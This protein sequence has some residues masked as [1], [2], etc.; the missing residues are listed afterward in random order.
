VITGSGLYSFGILNLCADEHGYKTNLKGYLKKCRNSTQRNEYGNF[1]VLIFVTACNNQDLDKGVVEFD[2]K[3]YSVEQYFWV[4]Q[5]HFDSNG[6]NNDNFTHLADINGCG[7]YSIK[8]LAD[9]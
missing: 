3:Q 5:S 9:R 6:L 8:G 1:F 7:V 2:H 4:K